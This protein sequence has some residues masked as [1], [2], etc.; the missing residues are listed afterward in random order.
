[1][2]CLAVGLLNISDDEGYFRAEPELIKADLMPYSEL[3]P[4][5]I[6]K[7]L[8]ELSVRTQWVLIRTH[9]SQGKIGFVVN[10]KEHQRVNRP[11]PSKLLK[12]WEESEL[13]ESSVSPHGGLTPGKEQGTGNREQGTGNSTR[14]RATYSVEFETFRKAY[15]GHRHGGKQQDWKSWELAK[16]AGL[17]KE[18]AHAYLGRW[19]QSKAWTRDGGQYVVALSKWLRDRYWETEPVDNQRPARALS[20]A[21]E[22]HLRN[23]EVLKRDAAREQQTMNIGGLLDANYETDDEV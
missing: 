6:S 21:E 12:Y 23:M 20:R 9:K 13:T 8:T 4:D 3:S 10:F 7:M 22:M 17:T 11:T 2:K 15:P 19:K 18:T 1:M 16:K 5:D 14:P